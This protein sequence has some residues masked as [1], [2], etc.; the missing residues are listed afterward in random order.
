MLVFLYKYRVRFH[1]TTL[2]SII[3]ILMRKNLWYFYNSVFFQHFAY[4]IIIP[5]LIIWQNRN[6]L[7]FSEIAFIQSTGLIFLMLSEL[8]SSFFADK[9]SRKL[10]ILIGLLT[11][12]FA[13]IFLIFASDFLLF[14]LFQIFFSIGLAFLSGTEEAFLHDI[15]NDKK[16]LTHYLGSMSVSDELGTMLG[17]LISSLLIYLSNIT[18]SF[19]A[20][21]VALLLSLSLII[22]IK[23][24]A[25]KQENDHSVS[26]QN[27]FLFGRLSAMLL[28][29]IFIF[30]LFSE[31]G[32]IIYQYSFGGLGINLES[33]G[34]IYLTA[35]I[36][37]VIGSRLSHFVETKIKT[38][39]SLILSGIFQIIAFVILMV[40]STIIAIISLCIFFFSENV[41]RNIRSSFILKNSPHGKR[42]TN[43]SLVSFGSSVILIFSK[44]IIGWSLDIRFLYAIIFVIALK[45]IAIIFLLNKRALPN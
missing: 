16:K 20:A 39:L 10:T 13:F 5:T 33:L 17:M 23:V 28:I 18:L 42:A 22:P 38:H 11:T 31:R 21:F 43:L 8:P 6:G 35:K 34:L 36:F 19:Q 32:E 25:S 24:D 15:V 37:S 14:I 29:F 27:M 40:N 30:G 3:A 12:M 45:I 2:D 9:V 1:L 4:G 7:S 41:F 26:N 44:L